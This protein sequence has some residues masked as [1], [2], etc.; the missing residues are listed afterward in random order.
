MTPRDAVISVAERIEKRLKSEQDS[1]Y[2]RALRHALDAVLK[3]DEVAK[4][5]AK[6][7]HASAKCYEHA[8]K[9]VR[10]GLQEELRELSKAAS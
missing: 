5:R 8:L 10:D 1:E 3:D 2:D 4:Q 6:E 7:Y 9:L